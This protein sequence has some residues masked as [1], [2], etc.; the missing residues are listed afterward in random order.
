MATRKQ[1]ITD[2]QRYDESFSLLYSLVL[3]IDQKLDSITKRLND[4][5]NKIASIGK[6]YELAKVETDNDCDVSE[7]KAKQ[8]ILDLFSKNGELDYVEIMRT[9]GLDLEL[10]VSICAELEAEKRIECLKR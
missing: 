5:E 3:S 8:M 1:S 2:W 6:V 9:T 4:I 7:D 10:I